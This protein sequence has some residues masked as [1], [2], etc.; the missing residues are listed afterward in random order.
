MDLADIGEKLANNA[1]LT[2][3][4]SD[5]WRNSLRQTQINNSY[6]AGLQNGS[7]N[8]SVKSITGDSTFLNLT[9]NYACYFGHDKIIQNGAFSQ[10]IDT[11]TW[12]VL[13][14]VYTNSIFTPQSIVLPYTNTLSTDGKFHINPIFAKSTI[15]AMSLYGSSF[16]QYPPTFQTM[17]I[18]WYYKS[19][20]SLYVGDFIFNVGNICIPY[21]YTSYFGNFTV[22]LGRLY[23]KLRTQHGR[24]SSNSIAFDVTFF[25]PF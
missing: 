2:P 6:I 8:I 3:Q 23:F 4:E 5:F 24:G 10:A 18:D 9:P 7:S 11:D 14:T 16:Y 12:T 15:R 1:R 13:T 22:D 21:I 17:V 19:D 25:M 20:D